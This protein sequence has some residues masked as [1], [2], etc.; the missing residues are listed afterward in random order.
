MQDTFGVGILMV[1]RNV[2][3]HECVHAVGRRNGAGS[4]GSMGINGELVVGLFHGFSLV[5]GSSSRRRRGGSRS[6]GIHGFV[7]LD[8]LRGFKRLV[9]A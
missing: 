2:G 8:R 1:I 5:G 6:G 9:D 7:R 3:I 4:V